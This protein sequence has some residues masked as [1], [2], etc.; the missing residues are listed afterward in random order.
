MCGTG[1]EQ[2]IHS[3][4]VPL[5]QVKIQDEFWDYYIKLVREV[6]VPYQWDALNDRVS[7]AEPSGAVRNFKIAAGLE[8]GDFYGM[9]FQDSDIAKWLEAVAYLLESQPDPALEEIADGLIDIIEQAQHEDGYLNTYFTLKEP[10]QRWTNLA[11][12]HELYCAGH[13]IEAAVAYYRA[14][15][16]RKLLDVVS[17]FAD[18]IDSVFGTEPGKLAGYD[19]H[20]E[21]ELALV[22]LYQVTGNERYLR[23][24]RYFL[25]QRGQKPSFYQIQLDERGGKTHWPSGNEAIDLEYNQSHLPVREQETAIGH[26]VRLLYMLTGMADVAAE[27]GDESLLAACRKLWDNIVSRQM[28]ITGGVG[29]MPQGEAFSFDYD[30]PNDTVYAETCASIG[31]IFFAQRMLKLAPESQF[32]DV[33]ERALYNTVVGGMSRDGKHFFYVNPL[34]VDPKACG[35]ANHKYDHVK[36]VRQEWFG[37]ACCP[38]NVARL[39][40]SLGE[41]IYTVQGDTIYT[42]L[43]IGGEAALELGESKVTLKQASNYP[44]DGEIKLEVFPEQAGEKFTLAVR[45]P[46]WCKQASLLLNGSAYPLGD[47]TVVNG[48]ARIE[49]EWQSGDVLEL[50]LEMPVLRMHS[51]PSVRANAGKVA[52]QRGPLVYCLEQAD[53]G[54]DLHEVVLPRDA[55]LKAAKEEELLGGVV[56]ISAEGLRLRDEEWSGGLYSPEPALGMKQATVKFIPYYAWANRGEGEMTVWVREQ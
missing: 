30:L 40:A 14:T 26:A 38:P 39:L 25:D 55:E 56:A 54:P 37:C 51:H 27:T 35:G 53:N 44:W 20:Q 18:H 23:L 29:S 36:P 9:V 43:Y 24:S 41:Y 33:M 31:L 2:S 7:G 12:C 50:R 11:E 45:I 16:K 8:Q 17:R 32:A 28:Y 22:K 19:G 47:N 15:G 6:V 52:L 49:R 42:H 1:A 3:A 4:R 10:G 48:Y 21:I 46:G 13:M 5:N 34:E